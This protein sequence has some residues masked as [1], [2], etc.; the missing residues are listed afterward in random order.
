M[1]EKKILFLSVDI[2]NVFCFKDFIELIYVLVFL[3]SNI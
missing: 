1:K 2:E 3:Y